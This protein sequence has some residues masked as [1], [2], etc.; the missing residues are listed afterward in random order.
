MYSLIVNSWWLYSLFT[1]ETDLVGIPFDTKI[2][3]RI[4]LVSS[5]IRPSL[6]DEN[7]LRWQTTALASRAI[8]LICAVAS[9]NQEN[10]ECALDDLMTLPKEY[11]AW[12][13]GAILGYGEVVDCATPLRHLELY[14]EMENN[15]WVSCNHWVLKIRNC[16][17][18]NTPILINKD[19]ETLD[20]FPSQT[21]LNPKIYE[22]H[23]DQIEKFIAQKKITEAN[24]RQVL[25]GI[26]NGTKTK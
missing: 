15:P 19:I 24:I 16:H 13:T 21:Q 8:E 25:G 18:F 9:K 22:M 5:G 1:E 14:P 20:L 12:T 3:G 2:K 4:L 7:Y 6:S 26:I 17:K 10:W 23:K 11:Q